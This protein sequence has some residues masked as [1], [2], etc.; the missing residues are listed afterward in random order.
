ME[1][2]TPTT[3]RLQA[4]ALERSA[5]SLQDLKK[6]GAPNQIRLDL[7][8]STPINPIP[9]PGIPD[10]KKVELYKK[11]RPLIPTEYQDITCPYPSEDVL[12]KIKGD[13]FI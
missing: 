5:I 1:A 10:I 7:M 8:K 12:K 4:D 9:L 2:G 3:L 11:Y 13:I 6:R